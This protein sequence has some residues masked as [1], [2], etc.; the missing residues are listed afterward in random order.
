M[1]YDIQTWVAFPSNLQTFPSSALF[2]EEVWVATV[3][4]K[5]GALGGKHRA[6][7]PRGGLWKAV[8]ANTAICCAGGYW[9]KEKVKFKNSIKIA[10]FNGNGNWRS[11]YLKML[12]LQLFSIPISQTLRAPSIYLQGPISSQG[13][14]GRAW[15]GWVFSPTFCQKLPRH[16]YHLLTRNQY[17]DVMGFALLWAALW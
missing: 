12:K 17:S 1:H 16:F 3:Y 5:R 11:Q 4:L 7:T 10:I 9:D 6:D 14:A 13:L 15:L 2:G 8:E